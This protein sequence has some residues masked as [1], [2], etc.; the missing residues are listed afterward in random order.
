MF[1]QGEDI[2]FLPWLEFTFLKLDW[3][4]ISEH[5]ILPYVCFFSVEKMFLGR[6][7]WRHPE[8]SLLQVPTSGHLLFC[9]ETKCVEFLRE[10]LASVD[11]N[12]TM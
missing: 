8:R 1:T 12:R 6:G 2:L 11:I 3:E 7:H 10:D 4:E 9:F 5:N